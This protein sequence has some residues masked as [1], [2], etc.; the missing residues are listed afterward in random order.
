MKSIIEKSLRG[1]AD[2]RVLASGLQIPAIAASLARS[3]DVFC[4]PGSAVLACQDAVGTL[5]KISVLATRL[6]GALA[7]S[8]GRPAL[9]VAPP[10][11]TTALTK[12][13]APVVLATPAPNALETWESLRNT[14]GKTWEAGQW[15]AD[16]SA[17]I[18]KQTAQR[19]REERE[20]I[21]KARGY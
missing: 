18:L 20:N 13:A 1:L 19:N 21:R 12:P 3:V 9:T 5:Q 2:T 15:Y 11:A 16:H 8:T 14:P 17:E 4:G 6:E 10:I 7:N